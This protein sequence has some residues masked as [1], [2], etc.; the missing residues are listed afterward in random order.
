[1]ALKFTRALTNPMSG[2]AQL[3]PE[4]TTLEVFHVCSCSCD[5]RENG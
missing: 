4:L 2:V 3:D 5:E 1:M